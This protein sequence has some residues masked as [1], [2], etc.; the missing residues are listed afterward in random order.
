MTA[1][2]DLD[3]GYD[4]DVRLFEERLMKLIRLC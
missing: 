3:G 2:A 4:S 1:A